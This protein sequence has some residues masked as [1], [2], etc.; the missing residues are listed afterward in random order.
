[1]TV[2]CYLGKNCYAEKSKILPYSWKV[3]EKDI[4]KDD[5]RRLCEFEK[6]V[7]NKDE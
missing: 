7:V 2:A 1:M 5:S 4:I 3:K 6:F